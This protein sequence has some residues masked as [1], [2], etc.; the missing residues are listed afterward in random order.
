MAMGT[1]DI[2]EV[3]DFATLAYLAGAKA[4]V[5]MDDSRDPFLELKIVRIKIF[6]LA[7]ALMNISY[8]RYIYFETYNNVI[9]N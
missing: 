1:K 8:N 3:F 7:E 5:I 4:L 2:N 9:L 6:A